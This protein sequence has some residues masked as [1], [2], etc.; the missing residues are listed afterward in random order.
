MGISDT[1]GFVLYCVIY[2][3][4]WVLPVVGYSVH[5]YGYGVGNSN[6]QVTCLNPWAWRLIHYSSPHLII[7]FVQQRNN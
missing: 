6:P 3:L 1:V 2:S 5:R 4:V 7:P